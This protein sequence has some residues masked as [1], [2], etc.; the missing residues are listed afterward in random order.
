MNGFL[1][2]FHP[3]RRFAVVIGLTDGIFTALALASGRL[4]ASNHKITVD[5]SARIAIA[6]SLS[7]MFIFFTAEYARLRGELVHA[8]KQLNLAAH[9]HLATTQLG[10]EVLRDARNAACVSSLCN[11]LGAFL[12][13]AVGVLVPAFPWLPIVTAVAALGVLGAALAHTV[14]GRMFLWIVALMISGVILAF[15]GVKVHVV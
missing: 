5:L 1:W 7:G 13:L 10:N 4:F 3:R 12:P 11:F 6:S 8:S 15:I 2:L 14:H 9:G